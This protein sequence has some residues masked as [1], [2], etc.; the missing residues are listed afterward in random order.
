MNYLSMSSFIN[1]Q[2]KIDKV[3]KG[4]YEGEFK[5]RGRLG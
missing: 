2:V 4:K 3:R 5:M 1:L